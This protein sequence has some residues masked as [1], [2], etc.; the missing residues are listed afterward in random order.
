MGTLRQLKVTSAG[1]TTLEGL[2]HSWSAPA[3]WVDAGAART[4]NDV[5]TLIAT[6]PN[7]GKTPILSTDEIKTG[8]GITW[9]V[10]VDVPKGVIEDTVL[11][12]ASSG[13]S[14]LPRR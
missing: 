12:A 3:T 5:Q 8:D 4:A 10:S 14:A 2:L 13:L 9:T 7:K 6:T 1:F 11:L